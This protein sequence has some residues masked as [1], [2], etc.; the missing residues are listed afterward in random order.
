MRREGARRQPSSSKHSA[1]EKDIQDDARLTNRANVRE[2]YYNF[3]KAR[4]FRKLPEKLSAEE[5]NEN[6]MMRCAGA[7]RW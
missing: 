2:G 3:L 4:V 1:G 5:Y 6:L 7:S